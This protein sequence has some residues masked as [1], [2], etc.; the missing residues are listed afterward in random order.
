[1]VDTHRASVDIPDP[2]AVVRAPAFQDALLCL[3]GFVHQAESGEGSVTG[4]MARTVLRTRFRKLRS[5]LV[6][7]GR[8]FLVLD[9]TQ[10]HRARKRLKR[11]RYLAEFCAPLFSARKT[12]AYVDALHPAQDALGFYND[13]LVA[14][15]T[16][17]SLAIDDPQAW[18]GVGWL[19]ARRQAN[20]AV[21]RRAL[22]E[23]AKV[24]T[25][26]R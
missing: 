11:L 13:E 22:E 14:L 2:G 10:Q 12:R 17:R 7:D 4:D 9:E 6:K 5:Q 24:D 18:F 15:E 19:S 1:M 23:L 25:F 20:S 16:Y 3:L 8:Q 26:W 21:C